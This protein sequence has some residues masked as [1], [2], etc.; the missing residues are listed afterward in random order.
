[1]VHLL[2]KQNAC[3]T[4]ANKKQETPLML[5]QAK[6]HQEVVS[7][8]TQA[9]SQHEVNLRQAANRGDTK[10]ME[11]ALSA[12]ANVNSVGQDS[13]EA[14]IHRAARKGHIPA[15]KLLIRF[16]ANLSL[17]NKAGDTPS[18]VATNEAVKN[19]IQANP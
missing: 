10:A 15:V 5:A 8:I 9:I 11:I 2:I 18:V 17:P 16:R 7:A 3:L 4:A 1:M 6:G 19:L 12:G 13:G 14:A